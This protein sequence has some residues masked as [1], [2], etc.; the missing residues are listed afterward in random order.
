MSVHGYRLFD[1]LKGRNE[2]N[3]N[4]KVI[5]VSRYNGLVFYW[6]NFPVIFIINNRLFLFSYC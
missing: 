2:G 4:T 6:V 5:T 1:L 3:L